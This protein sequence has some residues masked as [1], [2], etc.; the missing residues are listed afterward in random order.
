VVKG[1]QVET[2]KVLIVSVKTRLLVVVVV[3]VLLVPMQQFRLVGMVA[4]GFLHPL[5]VHRLVAVAVVVAVSAF[6]KLLE[7]QPMGA[8]T[9]A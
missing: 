9:V 1:S 2:V 8:E 6:R 3:P 5:P 4:L 7:R